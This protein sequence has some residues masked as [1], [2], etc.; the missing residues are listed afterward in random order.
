MTDEETQ[1]PELRRVK[2]FLE[3]NKESPQKYKTLDLKNSRKFDIRPEGW[4]M[5][6]SEYE[7]LV[8]I[9]RKDVVVVLDLLEKHELL[10]DRGAWLQ[11]WE[12]VWT[13]NLENCGKGPNGKCSILLS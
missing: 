5:L 6:R 1:I 13:E 4:P 12:D 10:R 8:D 7:K 3:I 2:E 11:R 9:A